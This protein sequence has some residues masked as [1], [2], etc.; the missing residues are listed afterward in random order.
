MQFVSAYTG[1]CSYLLQLTSLFA[2]KSVVYKHRYRPLTWG[3]YWHQWTIQRCL[4]TVCCWL[5]G[6]VTVTSVG[7]VTVVLYFRER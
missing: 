1:T 6:S 5:S 4:F 2:L 3:H 7:E